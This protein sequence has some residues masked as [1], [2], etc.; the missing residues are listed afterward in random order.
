[1]CDFTSTLVI[2]LK[3]KA[4]AAKDAET[5]KQ[6]KMKIVDVLGRTYGQKPP[7]VFGALN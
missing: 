5:Q 7:A 2:T 6:S 1:M 3:K 4:P